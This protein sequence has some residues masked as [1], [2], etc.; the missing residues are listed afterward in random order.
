MINAKWQTD[1][2]PAVIGGMDASSDPTLIGP[3]AAAYLRN[4]SVRGGRAKSRPRTSKVMTLPVGKIQGA[5]VFSDRGVVLTSIDGKVYEFR[6]DVWVAT[7][8]TDATTRGNPNRPRHW[9]CET[10]GSIVIQD[11]QNAPLI[12]DGSNFRKAGDDEVPVGGAMCFS[13]GRL[14]VVTGIGKS[15]RIGDV[16]QDAHQSE[17]KFTET[18]ALTGG[19]DFAFPRPVTSLHSLPVIDTSTGQGSLIVGC[20]E[21]VFSLKTQVASRDLWPDIGFQTEMFPDVGITGQNAATAVNQDLYFRSPDGLRSLR[22]TVGDFESPGQTPVS[23]EV[24]HRLDNDTA[25]LLEYA[26][27]AA[28]D[29][30]LLVTHSPIQYGNRGINLGLAVYNFDTLSKSGQKSPPVYDGEWDFAQIAEIVVGTFGGT[31]R[32]FVIGRDTAGVNAVWEIHRESDDPYGTTESP[33]QV[34]V[35]R[36]LVGAGINA[37]KAL[38]RCDVWLSDIKSAVNLKVYYRADQFPFWVLWDEFNVAASSP[39]EVWKRPRA[40]QRNPLSTRTT[41]EGFDEQTKQPLAQGFS[42]QVRLVW[43]GIARVDFVQLATEVIPQPAV[44]DNVEGV[45]G[46]LYSGTP[47]PGQVD[48]TFWYP[49]ASSPAPSS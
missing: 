14:A 44:A 29:N 33:E 27:V 4:V 34:L 30:R 35:T 18:F 43:T 9:Y 49:H 40:L 39:A 23:R 12:Y 42:F 24:A 32:C 17:L 15:V 41:P 46:K 19:G 13:N 8:K 38:R 5:G 2:V 25:H 10:I 3:T 45:D 20:R 36:S 26:T 22:T 28:F 7:E 6:P 37:Y 48:P 16:R 47:A 31:K 21:R 11:F 1:T